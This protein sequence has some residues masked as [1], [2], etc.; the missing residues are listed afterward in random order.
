MAGSAVEVNRGTK[1]PSGPVPVVVSS[2]SAQPSGNGTRTATLRA[3]G[4]EEGSP[5]AGKA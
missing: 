3:S 5:A 4:H 1:R 2:R